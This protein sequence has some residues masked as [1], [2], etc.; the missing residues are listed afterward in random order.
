[1]STSLVSLQGQTPRGRR[2]HTEL[3]PAQPRERILAASTGRINRENANQRSPMMASTDPI[4]KAAVPKRAVSM[5]RLDQLAQ[6]R[7]RYLDDPLKSNNSLS[8]NHKTNN[9]LTV[10]MSTAKSMSNLS[11][12]STNI[13]GKRRQHPIAA[14]TA[15][16]PVRSSP[17][18]KNR[19]NSMT[20]LTTTTTS[21]TNKIKTPPVINKINTTNKTRS[22]S[23]LSKESR[24]KSKSMVQ[25]WAKPP[26]A[27]VPQTT[28]IP[29]QTR[30]SRLRSQS[31]QTLRK[32][33]SSLTLDADCKYRRSHVTQAIQ[34][35]LWP[36]D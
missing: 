29:R 11:T 3:T 33:K 21:P 13:N 28:P 15:T 26:P 14:T 9:N 32:A 8:G 25:L 18:R 1:M 6:P 16:S 17:L 36:R 30:A 35:S 10:C 34:P 5:T 22:N 7:R 27:P 24:E 4:V 20:Q 12:Q 2:H 31:Q 23:Y 19:F